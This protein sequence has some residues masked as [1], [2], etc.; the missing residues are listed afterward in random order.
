MSDTCNVVY[1]GAPCVKTANQRPEL[2]EL[3]EKL[4]R[5]LERIEARV[6]NVTYFINRIKTH[7]NPNKNPSPMPL[8]PERPFS[9]KSFVERLEGSIDLAKDLE[10]QL[11]IIVERTNS[12]F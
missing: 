5:V 2:D 7:D 12:L 11:D 3:S 6:N 1:S 4:N 8:A 9:E 10:I